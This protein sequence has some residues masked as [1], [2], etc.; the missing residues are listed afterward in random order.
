MH[1]LICAFVVCIWHK[2]VFSW[3]GSYSSQHPPKASSCQHQ[4]P[5]SDRVDEMLIW[6]YA[7]HMSFCRVCCAPAHKRSDQGFEVFE[8]FKVC[9]RWRSMHDSKQQ[10]AG[11]FWQSNSQG[12][13]AIPIWGK[14]MIVHNVLLY[15]INCGI[16]SV[17][18][19]KT[20][21]AYRNDR[22]DR[23]LQ[24]V[25]TQIRLLLKEQSDQGLH[26]LQ[27]RLHRFDALLCGKA[28]LFNF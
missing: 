1:R 11:I 25:Q 8:V 5:W 19:R 27:F 3:G 23:P 10:R 15:S 4:H 26:C 18:M 21:R 7:V 20:V 28:T 13:P 16:W 2:H 17:K 6:V 9:W 24:T 12:I 22:T 14:T